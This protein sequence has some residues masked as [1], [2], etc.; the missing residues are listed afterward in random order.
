MRQ[1]QVM[2]YLM[3]HNTSNKVSTVCEGW[4]IVT[5]MNRGAIGIQ[6]CQT[7]CNVLT[8]ISKACCDFYKVGIND[9][10]ICISDTCVVADGND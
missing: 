2:A 9:L 5:Y 8:L 7:I 3:S 10:W 4:Q 1:S 6:E